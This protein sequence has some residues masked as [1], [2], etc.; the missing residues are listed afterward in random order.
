MTLTWA[1]VKHP[2]GSGRFPRAVLAL[3]LGYETAFAQ[4][5]REAAKWEIELHAVSL[6]AYQQHGSGVP[7]PPGEPFTAF[8]RPLPLSSRRVSSWYFGDGANLFN[9]AATRFGSPIPQITP[10]DSILTTSGANPGGTSFGVRLTRH[11]TRRVSAELL[12]ERSGKSSLDELA[13]RQ[14]EASRSSFA[15]ALERVTAAPAI[16]MSSVKRRGNT[17]TFSTGGIS[18]ETPGYARLQPFVTLGAGVLTVG[19]RSSTASLVGSYDPGL[20]MNQPDMITDTVTLS[21]APAK[22]HAFTTFVGGG[23]KV[24]M[25]S[26]LGVRVDLGAYVYHDPIATTLT[27]DHTDPQTLAFLVA[28]APNASPAFFPFFSFIPMGSLVGSPGPPPASV[29][30]LSGPRISEFTSFTERGVQ[31]QIRLSIG[32]YWRF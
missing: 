21:F 23:V 11:I 19:G 30:S 9:S 2:I 15:A 3:L 6:I 32:A 5:D 1:V 17:F 7:F 31:S 29:S 10:L 4:S 24:P 28:D 8:I 27:T 26:R 13:V 20:N 12:V 22:Q 14:I 25:T 18:I 16:S